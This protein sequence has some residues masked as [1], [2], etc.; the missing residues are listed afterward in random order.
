MNFDLTPFYKSTIG[1][2]RLAS[3]LDNVSSIDTNSN[4]YPPYNIEKLEADSYRITMAVAGFS[5]DDIAI[6]VK[7]NTLTITAGKDESD[8]DG[9]YL[10]RGIA[11]RAFERRF[12]LADYVEVT[13]ANLEHGLLHLDL[14]RE[15]PEA[16]KPRQIEIK[17]T[18]GKQTKISEKAA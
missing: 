14:K 6:E 3:L 8:D 18:T 12:R 4:G 15:I 10:Y 7:E 2:D 11:A 9:E 17:A 13:A 5:E 16:M 1:F